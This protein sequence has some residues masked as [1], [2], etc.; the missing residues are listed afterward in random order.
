MSGMPWQEIIA[1]ARQLGYTSHQSRT[2]GLHVHGEGMVTKTVTIRGPFC[3]SEKVSKNGHNKTGKQIYRCK[4]AACEHRSF[5]E[6][7]T[8]K[9]C[10]PEVRQQ[11]LKLAMDCTG[12]RANGRILGISKDSVTAI[13]KNGRLGLAG[14]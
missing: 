11:V 12:T 4:N 8:Y 14:E 2:C 7:Y 9:A 6:K 3:G 5:V 13:L 10:D 1:K